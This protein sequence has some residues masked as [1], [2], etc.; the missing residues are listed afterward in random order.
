MAKPLNELVRDL[1]GPLVRRTSAS[2]IPDPSSGSVSPW[3]RR[4][5]MRST[6]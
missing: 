6:G 4:V 5:G 2:R 3:L 1:A